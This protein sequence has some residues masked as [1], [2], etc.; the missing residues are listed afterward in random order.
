MEL[1][2]LVEGVTTPEPGLFSTFTELSGGVIELG[3]PGSADVAACVELRPTVDTLLDE[4]WLALDCVRLFEDGFVAEFEGVAA[5]P[6]GAGR[7]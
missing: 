3:S 7:V 1:L 2:L 4:F 5:T 6:L